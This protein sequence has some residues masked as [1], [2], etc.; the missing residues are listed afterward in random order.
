MTVQD[1]R[2]W[3]LTVGEIVTEASR[4]A[5]LL[6]AEETLSAVQMTAGQ[7]KLGRLIKSPAFASAITR[8]VTTVEVTTDGSAIEYT[9]DAGIVDIIGEGWFTADGEVSRNPVMQRDRKGF[10]ML[11]PSED[12]TTE[13]THFFVDRSDS[14]LVVHVWPGARVGVIRLPAH[15]QRA[16]VT[17]ANAT[18][19]LEQHWQDAIITALASEMMIAASLP[20]DRVGVVDSLAQ[21]KKDEARQAS[22]S[23]IPQRAVI[24]HK[25]PR[26]WR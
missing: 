13:P 16:D 21:R 11:Q 20:M 8:G 3:E 14:P 22:G 10:E 5:G 23:R 24:G 18:L 15:R 9:L 2:T 4:M 25:I 12:V 19:D 1:T 6:A 7:K 17:N 26:A